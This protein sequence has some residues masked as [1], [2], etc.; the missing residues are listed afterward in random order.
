VSFQ[1]IT[2][3]EG[4]VI[5]LQEIFSFKQTTVDAQGQVR[6][7]FVFHGVRP[8]FIEKFEVAGITVPP[9]LFDPEAIVEV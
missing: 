1:E 3:M 7:R 9:V 6:G 5:T 8:R 4:S 2:G